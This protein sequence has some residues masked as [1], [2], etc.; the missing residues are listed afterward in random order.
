MTTAT[1]RNRV[2]EM[3][4]ARAGDLLDHEGNWRV[5]PLFQRQAL[6]GVLNEV[7]IADALKAYYSPRNDGRLTLLDGHLRKAE[8]PDVEWPVIILDISDEEADLLLAHFDTIGGWAET[9][10]LKLD[11]LLKKANIEDKRL[12]EAAERIRRGIEDQVGIAKR[13]RGD[14]DAPEKREPKYP[15]EANGKTV[16]VVIPVGDDLTTIEKALKRAGVINRGEALTMICQFFLDHV[17]E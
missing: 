3:I 14:A 6:Q 2:K 12:K 5:H 10:A 11:E 8:T 13:L 1:P 15:F 4:Y 9:D 16:K 7:G 17:T